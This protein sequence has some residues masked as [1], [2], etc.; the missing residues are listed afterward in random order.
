VVCPDR[1]PIT[2][3][4]WRAPTVPCTAVLVRGAH[5]MPE[6]QYQYVLPVRGYIRALPLRGR[7][8]GGNWTHERKS[9][10]LINEYA[11]RKITNLFWYMTNEI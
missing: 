8:E 3:K 10:S 1:T 11:F 6:A 9:E 2:L 7:G 5:E 4:T